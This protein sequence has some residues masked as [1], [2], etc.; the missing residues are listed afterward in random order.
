[1]FQDLI[2]SDTGEALKASFVSPRPMLI[3]DS[4]FVANSALSADGSGRQRSAVGIYDYGGVLQDVHFVNYNNDYGP[5]YVFGARDAAVR[6]TASRVERA[7]FD[8]GFCST[9]YASQS[10]R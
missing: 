10:M 4:L 1:M 3:R 2:V 5:S 9:I 6:N 7:T 8:N